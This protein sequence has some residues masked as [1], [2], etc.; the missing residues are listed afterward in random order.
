MLVIVRA[1]FEAK[2][3]AASARSR[4]THIGSDIGSLYI[5]A[6]GGSFT[7]NWNSTYTLADVEEDRLSLYNLKVK[8]FKQKEY[9]L[10]DERIIGNMLYKKVNTTEDSLTW[11]K[12]LSG[13]LISHHI[14]AVRYWNA[15]CRLGE[16]KMTWGDKFQENAYNFFDKRNPSNKLVL[17]SEV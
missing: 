6:G 17:F 5:V 13:L 7:N 4:H 16:K 2:I 14:F 15:Q 1:V 8:I 12:V 11:E 3:S 10:D 9:E